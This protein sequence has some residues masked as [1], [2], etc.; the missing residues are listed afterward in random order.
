MTLLQK[1][2]KGFT[3]VELVL[4]IGISTL[5]ILTVSQFFVAANSQSTQLESTLDTEFA[6][7]RFVTEITEEIQRM[8]PGAA[9]EAALTTASTNALQFYSTHKHHEFPAKVKYQLNNKVLLKTITPYDQNTN[10]YNEADAVETVLFTT[11]NNEQ[12]QTA[13][14][15]FYSRGQSVY[16]DNPL[17]EPIDI[18][19]ISLI[20]V[21]LIVE[22][23]YMQNPTSKTYESFVQLP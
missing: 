23:K 4:C 14:F 17:E 1:N 15:S 3:L 8:A 6:A 20:T 2:T 13:L 19:Q 12:A 16:T 21:T 9:G 5:I 7:R 11:V 18:A 22:P 10:S